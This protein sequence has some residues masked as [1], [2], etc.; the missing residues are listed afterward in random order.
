M[1]NLEFMCVCQHYCER[2]SIAILLTM[3]D[4]QCHPVSYSADNIY[5]RNKVA[6]KWYQEK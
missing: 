4:K 3:V 5:V 6:E 1:E 2:S